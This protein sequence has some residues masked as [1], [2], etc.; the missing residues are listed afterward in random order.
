VNDQTIPLSLKRFLLLADCPLEWRGL[1]LYLFRDDAVVLYVGQSGFAFGRVWEHLLGG[2]HG[3]S[4]VG[5]FVWCNWPVS[6]NFTIELLGSGSAQFDLV[7]HDLDLA[8]RELIRRWSPC[9]NVSL[10]SQPT[11]V[12]G[13]YFPYNARIRCSRSLRRL[14]HQAK[15]LVQAEDRERWLRELE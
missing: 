11:A 13:A 1:D 15:R 7:G 14:V 2:F 6:M 4:V 8:E 3:H 9:F 10:N 12:P 5:R